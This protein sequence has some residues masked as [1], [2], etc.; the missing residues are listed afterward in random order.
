MEEVKKSGKQKAVTP[1]LAEMMRVTNA[2][3]VEDD[4]FDAIAAAEE[5]MMTDMRGR[6]RTIFSNRQFIEGN[7][8]APG[9][10]DDGRGNFVEPIDTRKVAREDA[11]DEEKEDSVL[12][13]RFDC[14]HGCGTKGSVQPINSSG[15][16]WE[17]SACGYKYEFS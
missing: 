14:S 9:F 15:R 12:L 6:G 16:D 2:P 3:S 7:Y 4:S 8:N 13:K 11:E 1:R 17:C 5:I 10:R